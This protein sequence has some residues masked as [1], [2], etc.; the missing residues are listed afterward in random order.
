MKNNDE[1]YK[2]IPESLK[3]KKRWVCYKKVDRG[4]KVAKLPFNA[5]NGQMADSTDSKTWSTFSQAALTGKW[6]DGI[7]Y[8]LDEG[9]IGID[10][11]GHIDMKLI[12]HFGS[13]AEKSQSGL[14][15]HIIMQGTVDKAYKGLKYEIYPGSAKGGR[16]FIVTADVIYGTHLVDTG[17]KLKEFIA[18]EF[19]PAEIAPR[20]SPISTGSSLE[21]HDPISLLEH[22]HGDKFTRLYEGDLSGHGDD[23]SRADLALMSYL[24]WACI[25]DRVQ[26]ESLFRQSALMRP[27]FDRQD[28]RDATWAKAQTTGVYEPPVTVAVDFSAIL[29]TSK[30]TASPWR[31]VTDD[32]AR[33]AING[34][35]LGDMVKIFE[36]VTKPHLP[37]ALTLPKALALSGCAFSGEKNMDTFAQI[38]ESDKQI[39]GEKIPCGVDRARLRIDT[40]GGAVANFYCLILAE[41]GM[42]KD[43]GGLLDAVTQTRG[44]NLGS[45]G[46]AEG[47]ADEYSRP[48]R[49][50]AMLVIPEFGKWLDIT[51]WQAKAAPLMT[52]LFSKGWFSHPMSNR[53]K[54]AQPR[55][56]KFCYPNILGSTQL[57]TFSRYVQSLDL[58]SGFVSRFLITRFDDPNWISWAKPKLDR[59]S[60]LSSLNSL[61][62]AIM[63]TEGSVEIPP[64]YQIRLS[65]PF[66][67]GQAQF[68]PHW[69]RLVSEYST[70]IALGL[71]VDGGKSIK[72][73][74]ELMDNAGIICQ[75]FYAMAE[76]T[77]CDVRETAA[78]SREARDQKTV[79]MAIRNGHTNKSVIG[80]FCPKIPK[81]IRNR[82]LDE[83]L[84]RGHIVKSKDGYSIPAGAPTPEGMG[85]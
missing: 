55:E 34:T 64:D 31:D 30:R 78:E 48:Q 12:K 53:A 38:T 75:W 16:Y 1:L 73:T 23:H 82:A 43:V 56:S 15:A 17:D 76:R 21:G 3:A 19:P 72:V 44:W 35:V 52:E 20:V 54:N 18:A 41:S 60:L 9:E 25:G 49:C 46:S 62:D 83:L 68:R 36:S 42:G 29:R 6:M 37:L 11:D 27:K 51:G 4:G 26:A 40:G 47:I 14:G 24:H 50:N 7:G 77:F 65:Q 74:N 13:Y 85:L 69:K 63:S 45:A 84:D 33:K 8:I 59:N 79:Y 57:T 2:N 5:R 70:R 81:E 58:E 67:R 28:Y 39:K 71:A 66:I 61:V 80:Q 10:M 32:H 22:T